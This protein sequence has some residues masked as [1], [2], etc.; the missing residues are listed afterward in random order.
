MSCCVGKSEPMLSRMS[1]LHWLENWLYSISAHDAP[2]PSSYLSTCPAV[3]PSGSCLFADIVT[4]WASMSAFTVTFS[5]CIM[6][7][8]PSLVE[9][10]CS[11][12]PSCFSLSDASAVTAPAIDASCASLSLLSWLSGTSSFPVA[13]IVQSLVV[14]VWMLGDG[15]DCG[16]PR[17]WPSCIRLQRFP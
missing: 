12:S 16:R 3:P 5:P 17:S 4:V 6:L 1:C 13:A 9:M 7:S 11:S 2:P 8:V 10:D 14:V 15:A